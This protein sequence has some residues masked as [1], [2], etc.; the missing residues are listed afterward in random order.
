MIDYIF[1]ALDVEKTGRISFKNVMCA[2][3]AF[4]SD[5]ALEQTRF[6]FKVYDLNGDGV[7]NEK[8]IRQIIELSYDLIEMPKKA[9]KG[10]HSADRLSKQFIYK[11]DHNNDGFVD[12]AEFLDG[13]SKNKNFSSQINVYLDHLAQ[14][15]SIC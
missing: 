4:S 1:N 5:C 7:I 15:F 8:E 3:S 2:F 13:F 11:F 14:N 6:L 10:P 9:R 12:L